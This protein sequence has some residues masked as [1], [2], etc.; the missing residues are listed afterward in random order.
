[1]VGGELATAR[2]F[3]RPLLTAGAASGGST[4]RGLTPEA[5]VGAGDLPPG[6]GSVWES[7]SRHGAGELAWKGE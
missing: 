3:K 1:M 6:G 5:V 4:A 7:L 2:R